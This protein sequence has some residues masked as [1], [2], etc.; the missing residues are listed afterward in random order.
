[1]A[2]P[3]VATAGGAIVLMG[4][5]AMTPMVR[6]L[7]KTFRAE[8]LEGRDALVEDSVGSSGG[9]RAAADGAIDIA[10]VARPLTARERGL[11]LVILPVARSAVVVAAHQ[12]V[13]RDGLSSGEYVDLVAGRRSELDGQTIA[14]LLRD[15]GESLNT[16]WERGLP[17]LTLAREAA[18]EANRSRVLYYDEA[19]MEALGTTPSSIGLTDFSLVMALRSVGSIK[20]LALDGRAPSVDAILDGS[21]PYCRDLSFVYLP[22]RRDRVGPFVDF[23]RSE[24]GRSLIRALHAAPLPLLLETDANPGLGPAPPLG[25]EGLE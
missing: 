16:T 11:G 12:N 24:R 13:H 5:G 1:M 22:S 20:P 25:P 15:R 3:P 4:T 17:A 21:W 19:M 7:A 10:L 23:V 6:E 2:P 8:S 9:V 18:Y 14:V